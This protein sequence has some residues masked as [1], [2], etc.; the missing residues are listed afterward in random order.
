MEVLS[1]LY[2]SEVLLPTKHSFIIGDVRKS[3]G[4]Y[5][6]DFYYKK[7]VLIGRIKAIYRSI[8]GLIAKK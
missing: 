7:M 1:S 2:V 3:M 8:K 4:V 5:Y 6:G